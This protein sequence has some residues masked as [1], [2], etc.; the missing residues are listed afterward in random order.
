MPDTSEEPPNFLPGLDPL[1]PLKRAR[2]MTAYDDVLKKSAASDLRFPRIERTRLAEVQHALLHKGYLQQSYSGREL[3]WVDGLTAFL[4]PSRDD[5]IA[6]IVECH[7]TCVKNLYELVLEEIDAF[8]LQKM[9]AQD[10]AY[11]SPRH[12][13]LGRRLA[14][15]VSIDRRDELSERFIDHVLRPYFQAHINVFRHLWKMIEASHRTSQFLVFKRGKDSRFG[16]VAP[17]EGFD[18]RGSYVIPRANYLDAFGYSEAEISPRL[19]GPNFIEEHDEEFRFLTADQLPEFCEA[20]QTKTSPK[21][22]SGRRTNSGFQASDEPLIKQMHE[23]LVVGLHRSISAAAVAVYEADPSRVLGG[24]TP[25]SKVK[26]LC[27]LY[28]RSY[29]P[30]AG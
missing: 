27:R 15:N 12:V 10:E 25:E 30:G 6:Q 16:M 26:R 9:Y 24:G 11:S 1:S 5:V 28:S 7:D 17:G 21:R 4:G 3:H 29:P 13:I 14:M 23:L 18:T 22:H 2:R 8:D 19:F 20:V